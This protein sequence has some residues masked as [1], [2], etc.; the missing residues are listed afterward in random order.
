MIVVAPANISEEEALKLR[1]RYCAKLDE[2]VNTMVVGLVEWEEMFLR[3]ALR[4]WD[5]SDHPP[6]PP[7][8]EAYMDMTATLLILLRERFPERAKDWDVRLEAARNSLTAFSLAIER[9]VTGVT[10]Q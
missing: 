8:V 10:V 4:C 5:L 1:E 3:T 9:E 2:V 7:L 6:L